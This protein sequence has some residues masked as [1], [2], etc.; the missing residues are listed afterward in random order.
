MRKRIAKELKRQTF[1][2]R[3]A[4]PTAA[5]LRMVPGSNGRKID[6]LVSI[7]RPLAESS[8]TSITAA[9]KAILLQISDN[10]A[11]AT[12]AAVDESLRLAS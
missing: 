8:P 9:A 2:G 11:V 1:T 3:L 10:I 4:P 12:Q 5:F 7:V 6:Y